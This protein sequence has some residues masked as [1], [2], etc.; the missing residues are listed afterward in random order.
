MRYHI[1]SVGLLLTKKIPETM[2]SGILWYVAMGITAVL[3]LYGAMYLLP[4][5]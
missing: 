1:A 5:K 2:R 3:T 4:W